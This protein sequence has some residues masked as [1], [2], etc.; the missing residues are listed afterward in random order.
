M[1]CYVLALG[2]S[3]ASEEM[4]VIDFGNRT[5]TLSAS[6]VDKLMYVEPKRLPLKIHN[7]T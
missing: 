2:L 3:L 4:R 5:V 1:L 7:I 6:Q